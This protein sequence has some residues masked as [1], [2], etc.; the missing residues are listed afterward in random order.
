LFSSNYCSLFAVSEFISHK[1]IHFIVFADR[2]ERLADY[3]VFFGCF[4]G[5][6]VSSLDLGLLGV[7][8]SMFGQGFFIFGVD[9]VVNSIFYHFWHALETKVANI[10][11]KMPY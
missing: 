9:G 4:M 6:G 10:P 2:I 5:N 7:V 1:L 3:F 8:D 11:G